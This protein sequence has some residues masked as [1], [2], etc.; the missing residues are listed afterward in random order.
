MLL[1][2]GWLI[3]EDKSLVKFE[4]KIDHLFKIPLKKADW[5]RLTL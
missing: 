3:F 5:N 2:F 1:E 4:M